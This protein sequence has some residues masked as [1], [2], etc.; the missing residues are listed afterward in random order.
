M[1]A[2]GA[3][4]DR[5]V[6]CPQVYALRG[7]N[8][9]KLEEIATEAAAGITVIGVTGPI[10]AGKSTVDAMLRALG[11]GPVIDADAVVHEL[12]ATS[13]P[14]QE[15]IAVAFGPQVRRADGRIDRKA[16][17]TRVFG[18][19]AALQRLQELVYPATRAAIR[20]RLQAASPGA[21]AVVD[22]VKLLQ[23]ELGALC[24]E[25]WWVAA[26]P[27]EQRRRLIEERG[28]SP[29]EADARLTAQP[30]LEDWRSRIDRV[31]DNSGSLDK[32][33]RQVEEAWSA[34]SRR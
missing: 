32:T 30:R 17:G 27:A 24:S 19:S 28:L 13:R 14:V 16:L 21:I 7:R 2:L 25:R 15:A 31:I 1:F 9:V 33:R 34:V 6:T 3:A 18:D 4:Q 20:V 5:L 10:A 8:G 23:G 26:D 29:A 11:A 22:A 12:Y